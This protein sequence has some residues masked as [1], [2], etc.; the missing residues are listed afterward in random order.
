MIFSFFF[1]WQ[2]FSLNYIIH[3]SKKTILPKHKML[4]SNSVLTL[5]NTV[6]YAPKQINTRLWPLTH[7]VLLEL[8]F[9]QIESSNFFKFLSSR[10]TCDI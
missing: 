6:H 10:K 8:S 3:F 5:S 7:M 2:V 1:F 9:P 4:K